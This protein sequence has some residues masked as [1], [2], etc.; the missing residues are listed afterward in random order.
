[1]KYRPGDRVKRI[2]H[3]TDLD[4][5]IISNLNDR[6]CIKSIGDSE[7]MIWVHEETIQLDTEYYREL[8]INNLLDGI[9]LEDKG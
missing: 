1:M 3:E 8:K 2:I 4:F 7:L 9:N 6:Y 5:E